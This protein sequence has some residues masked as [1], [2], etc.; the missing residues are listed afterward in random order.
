MELNVLTFLNEKFSMLEVEKIKPKVYTIEKLENYYSTVNARYRDIPF[1]NGYVWQFR[2]VAFGRK[3]WL[4]LD[5]KNFYKIVP[6]DNSDHLFLVTGTIHADVPIT[7]EIRANDSGDIS[8]TWHEVAVGFKHFVFRTDQYTQVIGTASFG[9]D[10]ATLATANS[11][12]VVLGRDQSGSMGTTPN[13]QNFVYIELFFVPLRHVNTN[14][15]MWTVLETAF[16]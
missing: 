14:E 1:R 11:F 7:V 16:Q 6:E 4:P 5:S 9:Y 8:G 13:Y 15:A 3:N 12:Y 2:V 10:F